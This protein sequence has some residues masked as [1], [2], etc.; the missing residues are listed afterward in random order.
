MLLHGWEH[1]CGAA[2]LFWLGWS[3]TGCRI[4]SSQYSWLEIQLR[5]SKMPR[6]CIALL[7][8]LWLTPLI[9]STREHRV[10]LQTI[11]GPR[12]LYQMQ[13]ALE[14]P[15]LTF[16]MKTVSVTKAWKSQ[17]KKKLGNH[18]ELGIKNRYSEIS[19]LIEIRWQHFLLKKPTNSAIF[20][21]G[22]QK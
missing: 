22:P 4:N 16:P 18:A 1:R 3:N 12:A 14:T 20:I 2:L 10:I 7:Q 8:S 6:T 15:G 9:G 11:R 13:K 17:G 21:L 5:F 19:F